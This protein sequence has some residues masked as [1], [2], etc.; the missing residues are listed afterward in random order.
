MPLGRTC[1]DGD[2]SV[3]FAHERSPAVGNR[4]LRSFIALRY[5]GRKRTGHPSMR[6]DRTAATDF[7]TS[8]T[9][10]RQTSDQLPPHLAERPRSGCTSEP[11]SDRRG[12]E[13]AGP[14]NRGGYGNFAPETGPWWPCSECLQ[15][16]SIPAAAV[17]ITL[18]ARFSSPSPAFQ[19]KRPGCPPL[20]GALRV[21]RSHPMGRSP[22][23]MPLAG[24][25]KGFPQAH[26]RPHTVGRQR[27]RGHRDP[28]RTPP[29]PGG[30]GGLGEGP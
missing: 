1:D 12:R 4:R 25:L 5:A 28:G 26:Y 22:S 13:A 14:T 9:H 15:L 21:I 20:S 8:G 10:P 18:Q 6:A 23:A 30:G 29:S 24:L 19:A 11:R 17:A 16:G 2:F 27:R 3:E 7:R